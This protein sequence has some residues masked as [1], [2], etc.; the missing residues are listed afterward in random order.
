MERAG[1][2]AQHLWEFNL[3]QQYYE[4]ALRI[5]RESEDVESAAWIIV[6]LGW[7]FERQGDYRTAQRMAEEGLVI[8]RNINKFY[9]LHSAAVMLLADLA[10]LR[11]DF[12]RAM[13][14]MEACLTLCLKSDY[15]LGV[16][17]RKTRLAQ[18]CIATGDFPRARRLLVESLNA[19]LGN[20]D[21]WNAAMILVAMMNLLVV[22]GKLGQAARCLG[23]AQVFLEI[24]G[25]DLWPVDRLIY[26]KYKLQL[27]SLL[28]SAEFDVVREEGRRLSSDVET[29]LAF[30][31]ALLSEDQQEMEAKGRF[32]PAGQA[33]R[34]AFDGLT[35][36]EREVAVL[37]AQG[38]NNTEISASLYLG[39][40]TV[41]AHVTKILTKLGYTSRTQIA[42]WAV[43]KG[44]K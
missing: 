29:V 31:A 32:L 9:D 23:A 5:Y 15:R 11:G 27:T 38:K 44:L 17:R 36:R 25:A 37:I 14:H 13:D 10:Y 16:N 19:S 20:G 2:A 41:E 43:K 7:L 6:S 40:R 18:V 8:Y 3:A 39:V 1:Y 22:E 35:A 28:S 24:F 42:V 34:L 26:E 21:R 12:R 33:A 30:A 4:E